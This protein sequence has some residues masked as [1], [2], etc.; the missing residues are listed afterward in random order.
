MQCS[1][2]APS[3]AHPAFAP[4]PTDLSDTGWLP[5]HLPPPH[6]TCLIR[7]AV[8][9][10]T[11]L[12]P[13]ALEAKALEAVVVAVA[14]VE[15]ALLV[16]AAAAAEAPRAALQGTRRRLATIFRTTCVHKGRLQIPAP[17]PSRCRCR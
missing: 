11:L 14:G 5:T 7:A 4:L 1:A 6:H 8:Q 17:P 9:A 13:L 12:R 2:A 15:L 10:P 16:A 3:S